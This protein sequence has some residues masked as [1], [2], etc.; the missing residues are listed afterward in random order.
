[1]ITADT[2][3]KTDTNMTNLG[4]QEFAALFEITPRAVRFYED[5]GLLS[6]ARQAGSRV[7]GLADHGRMVR[8]LRA[9]RLGFTLD[10]I[11]TVLD[12]TD[13]LITDQDELIAR[14]SNFKKVIA[15][16][17][18]RRKDIDILTGEMTELCDSIDSFIAENP[19]ASGAFKYAKAYDAVLRQYMDDDFAPQNAPQN[20]AGGKSRVSSNRLPNK[21]S[22]MNKG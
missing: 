19:S 9:K 7:F 4:I 14:Q 8:I 6:P 20:G 22:T 21:N 18:R 11:K 2:I 3:G 1:M 16:L 13:G 15:S 17:R 10:D 5:K 12:V